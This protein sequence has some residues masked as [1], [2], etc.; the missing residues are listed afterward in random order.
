M[1]NTLDP[2]RPFERDTIPKI[3][4]GGIDRHGGPQA[5]LYRAAGGTWTPL[6]HAQVEARVTALA[7]A[8]DAA[9]I[10]AGDRVAILS[11]NRPEWAITDYAATGLGA[12]DVPIYPTLPANQ[13]EYILRDCE[14]K[15]VFVS[16]PA[17]AARRSARICRIC[18]RS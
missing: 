2:L 8:L 7:A 9:G 15:I 14:A 16:T 17:Q 5:M 4:F 12:I 1:Q 3:F 6:S 18:G 11:E 10:A 13:V